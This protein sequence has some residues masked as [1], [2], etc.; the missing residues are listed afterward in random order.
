ML[1]IQI[2]RDNPDLIRQGLT[3]RHLDPSPVDQV[4]QLDAKRRDLLQDVE[5]LRA[6][7]N[8]ESKAIGK[9]KDPDE[10]QEKIAA[11]GKSGD[12]LK[13][14]ENEL[15]EVEPA[16][17]ALVGT[18]P[19][20]PDERVPAGTDDSE[21]ELIKTIGDKPIF[22]FEPQAHWDLGPALG[23][24]DFE[25]GVKLSGTRFYVLNG[26]GARLQRSLVSFMLDTHTSHGYQERYTPFMVKE[27]IVYASG[28]L[29]KFGDNL[30]HDHEEDFWWVPTAEVPLTGLHKDEII[31]ENDLPLE[32][33]AYSPC[34]RREKM[35]A[36]REVRG[37]KRGHQFDK[38]EMYIYC[39]P[40][41]SEKMFIRMLEDSERICQLLNLPY[42]V[43]NLCTGDLGFVAAYTHDIEVWAAGCN[44]WLE[45]SSISNTRDFQARRAAIRYRP[46]G[47]K[48]TRFVHTLN[49]SGLGL[50]RVMIAI[51]EN[52]QQKDGS[53]VIPEVLR[54]WM[55]GVDVINRPRRS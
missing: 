15:R 3:K 41:E 10:R 16:L 26:L 52:N 38:V 35:S 6:E 43:N 32:Y 8:Q 48:G 18:F 31:D 46:E 54:P 50:P 45:V 40:E 17:S 19:N 27:E 55:G 12:Q 7:R 25:R 22:D 23:I 34:F 44:E 13:S 9:I 11:M 21:N 20:L 30:Y 1:D 49:G 37:I 5:R 36:G 2:F 53:V 42:R 14:F 47:G 39:T 28:Q 51:L 24:L 4:I 29:P 33:T